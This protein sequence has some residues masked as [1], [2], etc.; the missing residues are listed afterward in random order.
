MTE[1]AQ[2]T[3]QYSTTT[4]LQARIA[5]HERFSTNQQDWMEWLFE[6]FKLPDHAQILELGGGTGRLWQVNHARLGAN[7]R[8]VYSDGSAAMVEQARQTLGHDARFRF[9]QIDAHALPFADATFDAVIANHMLY[10]VSDKHQALRA[11]KRVLKP[12]GVLYAATNGK[13]HLRELNDL[14]P[15]IDVQ[16]MGMSFLLDNGAELLRQ[17]F[18]SVQTVMYDCNLAVTEIEPVLDYV[19]SLQRGYSATDMARF[20]QLVRERMAHNDG[21]FFI[22]KETG[23][24]V[25]KAE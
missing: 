5:L 4:N 12:N 19:R 18:G 17:H 24:L 22:T 3:Q 6:Q 20:E 13:R 8:I 1:P 9:E 23:V 11:I 7:W 25:A 21:V 10:H 15:D 2:I 14:A 16:R